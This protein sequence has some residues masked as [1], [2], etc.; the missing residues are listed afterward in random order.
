MEK[1]AATKNSS[2]RT[3][4]FEPD[5]EDDVKDSQEDGKSTNDP[6]TD[7]TAE[8]KHTNEDE[9]EASSAILVEESKPLEGSFVPLGREG[10]D[11]CYQYK[12]Q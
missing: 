7:A 3:C 9:I 5:G 2:L 11:G 1:G 4:I 10:N 12:T 6:T 8:G